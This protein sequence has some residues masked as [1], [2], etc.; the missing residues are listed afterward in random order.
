[1][2]EKQQRKTC[3][4]MNTGEYCTS[5]CKQLEGTVISTIDEEFKT[6]IEMKKEQK[7]FNE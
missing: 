7:E 3:L 4:I 2:S 5:L 6:K 1:M